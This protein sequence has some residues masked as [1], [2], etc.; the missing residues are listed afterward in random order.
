VD[1]I[2]L[3]C[4][5]YIVAFGINPPQEDSRCSLLPPTCLYLRVSGSR[6]K[7]QM[8]KLLSIETHRT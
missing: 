1:L 3:V 8:L 4:G 5:P 6:S 2:K 7:E